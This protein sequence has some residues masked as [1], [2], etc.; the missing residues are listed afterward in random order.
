MKKSL[1]ALAA[2]AGLA[3]VAAGA[4]VDYVQR[5]V[6]R[7]RVL[8]QAVGR[9]VASFVLDACAA[10]GRALVHHL[11]APTVALVAAR[12]YLARQVKRQ[13]P[14]LATRWRMCPSA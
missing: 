3:C 13:R 5:A 10:V 4:C 11:P 2:L 14:L 9:I 6:D 12:Q 7:T 1:F 8:A